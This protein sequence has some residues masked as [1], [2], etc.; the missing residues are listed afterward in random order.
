MLTCD[1]LVVY[2]LL[3]LFENECVALL[4]IYAAAETAANCYCCCLL[5]CTRVLADRAVAAG[6]TTRNS[7]VEVVRTNI[8]PTNL[9]IIFILFHSSHSYILG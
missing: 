1:L 3:F 4:S 5:A 6:R 7:T 8:K 9:N 2:V